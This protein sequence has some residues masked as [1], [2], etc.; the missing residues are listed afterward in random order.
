MAIAPKSTIRR[1]KAFSSSFE[2]QVARTPNSFAVTFEDRQ[3]TYEALNSKANQ[4]AHHLRELGVGPEHR[5]GLCMERGPEMLIGV[6]G[7]LKAGASYVPLDPASPRERLEF[8]VAE[9][10]ISILVT[11]AKL[12]TSITDQQVRTM[13]LLVDHGASV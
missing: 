6:L 13:W 5:V 2:D 3:F 11:Q 1:F 8:I 7:I 12:A 4:L 9:A 10:R